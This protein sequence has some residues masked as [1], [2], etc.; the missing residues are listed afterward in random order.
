MGVANMENRQAIKAN[1]LERINGFKGTEQCNTIV[2]LLNVMMEEIR[3]NNDFCDVETFK[4]NQGSIGVL[5]ILR[6]YINI[7]MPKQIKKEI[8]NPFLFQP[9]QE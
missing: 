3:E 9:G 8:F 2:Q 6:N 1:L 7:G 5:L 4:R